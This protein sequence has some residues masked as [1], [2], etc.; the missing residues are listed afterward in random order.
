MSAKSVGTDLKEG[1][2]MKKLLPVLLCLAIALGLCACGGTEEPKTPEVTATPEP[3]RFSKEDGKLDTESYYNPNGMKYASV[4]YSYDGSGRVISERHLGLN[5]AEEGVLSYEYLDGDKISSRSYKLSAGDGSYTD[6]YTESYEYDASGLLLSITRTESGAVTARTVYGYDESGNLV[7]EK[8][9]EGEDFCIAE[10]D[11]R[12]DANGRVISC[13]RK[14]YIEG[15]SSENNYAYDSMGR[16]LT[17]QCYDENGNVVS[18]TEYSYDE[19][20]NEIKRSVFAE[21]GELISSTEK[22]YEYDDIGN[23]ICC[24][25]SHSDGTPGST[26][27]YTWQ[28]SKG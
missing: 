15:D 23:I 26:V 1:A 16:L 22:S 14:D 12:I 5:D 21:V 3:V 19:N 6:Y 20:G 24:V 18:R 28:Y 25:T 8:R 2:F 27:R 4:E 7:S 17:D 10:Y 9:Y 11:Y 13:T